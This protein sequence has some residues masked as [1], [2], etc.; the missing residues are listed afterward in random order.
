MKIASWNVN[1]LKI[2]LEHVLDYCRS[3]Q[4]DCLMLQ[5][6]KIEDDKF[7]HEAFSEIGWHAACH[8][9]KGYNGV[10]LLSRYPIEIV[11]TT[12]PL[13]G[14]AEADEQ[15]R[16]LEVELKG[17]RLACLYLPNGNPRPGPKFDYKIRWMKR[18]YERAQILI[19][20]EKPVVMAGDYNVIPYD[21]DCYDPQAWQEDA[22]THEVCR[23]IFFSL[24]HLGFTDA[25]R[26]IHPTGAQYSFWDYQASAWARDNGIRIDHLLLSPEAANLLQNAGVDKTPRG[27]ERPSDHTPVW[28]EF[29]GA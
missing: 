23:A 22:L 1:S 21:V 27:L 5:E 20:L 2:R 19:K 7:P 8:G 12:L 26:A 4:A 28:A 3:G 6:T 16:Y 24:L 10:A 18:L 17:F 29:D 15:A 25:I 14:E 9:Q 11:Q 13:Y